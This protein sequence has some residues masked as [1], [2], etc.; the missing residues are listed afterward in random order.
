MTQP[1]SE[2]EQRYCAVPAI[3]SLRVELSRKVLHLS[4]SIIPLVYALGVSR[5]MM[6]ILLA[7]CV[8]IAIAVEVLRHS[9]AVIGGRFRAT[10]GFMVRDK[11]WGRVCGATYVLIAAWLSVW[12]FPKPVAIAS[13][14]ILSISDSAASL[15]GIRFGKT[16]F[17]GKSVAGSSAFF[18]TAFGILYWWMPGEELMSLVAAAVG[19]V[20]EAV[21]S[22]RWGM[23]ELS[24]NISIP[25]SCGAAVLL[26]R[27]LGV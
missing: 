23:F 5:E 22:L 26:M 18:L 13:I 10:V 16:R 20:A 25:L 21:P 11:E 1:V 24:D 27:W 15:I 14:L 6:L 4:T 2:F 19:T 12:L 3:T 9:S 8:G 17:L 7:V